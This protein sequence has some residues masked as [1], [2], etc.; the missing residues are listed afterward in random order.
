MYERERTQYEV[1]NKNKNF[2]DENSEEKTF[3]LF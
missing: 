3:N 2:T 1:N